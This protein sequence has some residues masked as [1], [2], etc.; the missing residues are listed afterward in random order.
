[1][2]LGPALEDQGGNA[3]EEAL[4]S[5]L[6]AR[7]ANVVGTDRL[8]GFD[9]RNKVRPLVRGTQWEKL[10]ILKKFERL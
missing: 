3:D 2:E 7:R 1:M 9:A 6:R 10:S 5:A 4:L 8:R